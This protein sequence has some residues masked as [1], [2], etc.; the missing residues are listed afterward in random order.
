MPMPGRCYQ[1][2]QSTIPLAL[3]P[4]LVPAQALCLPWLLLGIISRLAFSTWVLCLSWLLL[5]AAPLPVLPFQALHLHELLQGTVSFPIK[6]YLCHLLFFEALALIPGLLCPIYAPL[7]APDLNLCAPLPCLCPSTRYRHL[8]LI[9][10][11]WVAG[12]YLCPVPGLQPCSQASGYTP[13]QLGPP[14]LLCPN[15]KPPM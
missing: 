10:G 4:A 11:L 15:Q 6:L 5:N 2:Y 8:A 12:A 9:S 7:Q 13:W 14:P 3:V 1:S